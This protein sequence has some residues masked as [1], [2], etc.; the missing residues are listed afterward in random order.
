L[1]SRRLPADFPAGIDNYRWHVEIKRGQVQRE[2][3]RF[4]ENEIILSQ[5]L[6]LGFYR[7]FDSG[8]KLRNFTG[9]VQQAPPAAKDS[10]AI[11]AYGIRHIPRL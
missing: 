1:A 5:E 4:R 2:I 3:P 8:A 7:V 11:K 9:G 10:A 6:R